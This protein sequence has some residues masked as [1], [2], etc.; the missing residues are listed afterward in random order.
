MTRLTDASEKLPP[1]TALRFV[2]MELLC[3]N[4]GAVCSGG[5][6]AVRRRCKRR[7]AALF[8]VED[9]DSMCVRNVC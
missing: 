4:G 9:G 2:K 5:D 3:A 1:C 6:G 7:N 8:R